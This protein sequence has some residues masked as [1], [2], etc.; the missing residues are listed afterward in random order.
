MR[1]MTVDHHRKEGR[2]IM[3]LTGDP[4]TSNTKFGLIFRVGDM[5]WTFWSFGRL[6]PVQVPTS[7]TQRPTSS[8]RTEI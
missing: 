7:R 4:K 8:A 2:S 6:P 1:A 5:I 3:K